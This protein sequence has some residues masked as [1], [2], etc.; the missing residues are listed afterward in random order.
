MATSLLS[1][2]K[3]LSLMQWLQRGAIERSPAMKKQ[4]QSITSLPQ[5]PTEERHQRMVRY[6]IAMS[7]RMLCFI[8][9]FIVPGWWMLVCAIG[10]VVLP[11]FAVILANVSMK[12]AGAAVERPGAIIRIEPR[13]EDR[14]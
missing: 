14:L 12:Q 5:S 4:Q 2:K 9:V 11:Y 10:A 8:L 13:P 7:I 1:A 3:V 6:T